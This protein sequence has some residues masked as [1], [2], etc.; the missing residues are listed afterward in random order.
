M[1]FVLDELAS[2][3]RFHNCI[4]QLPRIEN[5]TTR[6]SSVSKD[7]ANL[8]L[9][10]GTKPKRCFLSRPRKFFLGQVNPAQLNGLVTLSAR[11]KPSG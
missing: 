8:R 1:W 11:S 6:L 5:R 7:A 10:M 4:Q 2:L 3:Q 9:D